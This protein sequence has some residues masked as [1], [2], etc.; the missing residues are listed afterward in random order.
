MSEWR[1]EDVFITGKTYPTPHK[2]YLDTVCTGGVTRNGNWIRL[3]PISYRYLDKERQYPIYSWLR[4]RVRKSPRDRRKE[5]HAVDE[6]SIQ[7]LSKSTNWNE[8]KRLLIPLLDPHLEDLMERNKKDHNSVSMGIVEI[9]Y[10]DFYWR[11]TERQWNEKQLDYMRQ[12]QLIGPERK[13]LEKMP[14]ELRLKYRCKGNLHCGGHD[15]TIFSWEYNQTFRAWRDA[16]KYGDEHEVLA[17]MK[18]AI[19]DRMFNGKNDIY[20]L[21]GTLFGRPKIWIVGGIFYPPKGN[22]LQTPELW[23]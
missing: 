13:P 16:G 19:L 6:S 17:K 9:E 12:M 7:V 1:E 15:M 21:L 2:E 5:S 8:R 14:Y 23:P 4:V 20:V 3:W 18:Q 10:E 22:V 11:E